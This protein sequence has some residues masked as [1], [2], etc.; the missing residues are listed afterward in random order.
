MFDAGCRKLFT[1]PDDDEK[2][3]RNNNKFII[4]NRWYGDCQEF[5]TDVLISTL[6]F[7]PCAG[8]S[9]IE[10]QKNDHYASSKNA[11]GKQNL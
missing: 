8:Q 10:A 5:M 1:A 11:N 7:W 3:I 4:N 2:S 9:K 6:K